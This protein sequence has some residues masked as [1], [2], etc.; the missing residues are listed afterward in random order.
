M[1]RTR[2]TTTGMMPTMMIPSNGAM[3]IHMDGQLPVT[4]N[5]IIRIMTTRGHN[6][7]IKE[8]SWNVLRQICHQIPSMAKVKDVA[9]VNSAKVEDVEDF[10]ADSPKVKEMAKEVK[11][12]PRVMAIIVPAATLNELKD[13]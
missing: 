7:T 5:G 13:V 1:M 10:V 12:N 6:M 11:A 9:K 2:T 4:E 8:I 3:T